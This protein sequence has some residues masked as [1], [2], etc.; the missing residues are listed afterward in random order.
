MRLMLLLLIGGGVLAFGLG[1]WI[2][3]G[4]PGMRTRTDRW[5]PTGARRLHRHY[6]PIDWLRPRQRR[7]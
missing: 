1:I 5:V 6:M 4:T 7:H 2:G 3:L